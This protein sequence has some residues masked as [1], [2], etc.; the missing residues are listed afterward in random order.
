MPLIKLIKLIR[1]RFFLL[2]GILPYFLGQAIAFGLNKSLNWNYFWWG[3]VGIFLVLVAVELFN[4]Y[5]DDQYGGDRIFSQVK[6]EIPKYFFPCGILALGLAFTVGLYLA[7]QTGW[8]VLLFSFLGFL[9]AYFYVGP[10]LKW[11][12]RGMGELIIAL[13]YG[14][15]MVLGSY[16]IQA[17]RIVF[18]PF[19][20]S[21][22]C[23]LSMFSLAVLNEVPDYYQDMLVGKRNLVVKL[24]KQKAIVLLKFCLA[25]MFLLLI[26]GVVFKTIPLLAITAVVTLP[27]IL[28]SVKR[29]EKDYDNPKAFLLAVNTVVVTHIVIAVSLGIGFLNG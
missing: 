1:Y 7:L 14:P 27:W 3:F 26:L 6:V 19:F 12:Y 5:F 9:G 24:G 28:K 4:E 11:A 2:A 22:I 20:V 10:P 23:G 15:L 16:Y 21:L 8:P 29:I 17:E 13:S 18:V 25:G